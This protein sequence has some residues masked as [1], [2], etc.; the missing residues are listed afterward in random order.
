M[1]GSASYCLSPQ[2]HCRKVERK[3]GGKAF[4]VTVSGKGK[5]FST[6]ID[7]D[8]LDLLLHLAVDEALKL[9]EVLQYRLCRL[10]L[11]ETTVAG[12]CTVICRVQYRVVVISSRRRGDG[13]Y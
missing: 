9:L 5:K 13:P 11:E 4:I 8:A 2:I 1:L 10:A 3:Q 6:F 12:M 7:F